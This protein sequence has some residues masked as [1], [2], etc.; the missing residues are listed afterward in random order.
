MNHTTFELM[1]AMLS[2]ATLLGTLFILVARLAYS[3]QPW[4]KNVIDE[5]APIALPLTA[6]ITTTCMIGSLYFSE[7]VNYVPC[8]LCWFQRSMMYPLAIILLV[9]SAFRF[10]GRPISSRLLQR[11]IVA[12]A[13]I[14]AL[15]STYHW[16]EERFPNLDSGVC[17]VKVPCSFVW[18]E[19]FGFVTLPFMAFTGFL[20]TIVFSTLPRIST[21]QEQL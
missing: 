17:D 5:F 8:R 20:A 14:G 18:F 2:V 1:F 6:A 13:A 16:F 11:L 9:A 4:A 7:V 15:I 10:S 21:T 3:S 19:L 12:L